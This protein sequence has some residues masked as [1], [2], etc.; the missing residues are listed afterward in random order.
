MKWIELPYKEKSIVVNLDNV[1]S[2]G[3]VNQKYSVITYVGDKEKY[4]IVELPYE[5]LKEKIL[6]N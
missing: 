4:D 6:D 2:F 1:A 5:E 3:P